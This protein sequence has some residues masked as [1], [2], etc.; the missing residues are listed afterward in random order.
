MGYLIPQ[1]TLRTDYPG[2]PIETRSNRNTVEATNFPW[3]HSSLVNRG[4]TYNKALF[5]CNRKISFSK[6]SIQ[7]IKNNLQ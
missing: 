4:K 2:D 1:W 3:F 7:N 6:C 5:F